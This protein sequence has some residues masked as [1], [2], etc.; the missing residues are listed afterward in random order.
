MR[1]LIIAILGVVV[2][3][4]LRVGALEPDNK[5]LEGMKFARI[6]CE[7]NG[8]PFYKGYKSPKD[9]ETEEFNLEE[10]ETK[11]SKAGI[12]IT[13]DNIRAVYDR[14]EAQLKKA[15]IQVVGIRTSNDKGGS[16]ILPTVSV[17]VEVMEASKK[18]YFT[19]V[20]LTVSKWMSTWSGTQ[21]IRTTVI[22]WWQKKMLAAGPKELNQSIEK[23]VKEL[24]DDFILQWKEANS[25]EE[26]TEKEQ[27]NRGEKKHTNR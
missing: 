10:V 12:P 20:S 26:E 21:N 17:N 25:K 8:V 5:N 4:Y 19:L 23:V 22:T 6:Q 3:F 2:I 16:T 18:L 9:Q 7:F 15:G 1:N 24:I 11:L 27:E 13:K 14:M